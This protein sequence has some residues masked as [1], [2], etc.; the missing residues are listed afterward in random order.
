MKVSD[1]PIHTLSKRQLQ[2][3]KLMQEKFAMARQD[4]KP[5]WMVSLF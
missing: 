3:Q 4:P 5:M 2:D 1:A